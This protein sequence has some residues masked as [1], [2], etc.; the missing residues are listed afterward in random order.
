MRYFDGSTKV[1]YGACPQG[2]YN[3][4]LNYDLQSQRYDIWLGT[5]QID[6]VAR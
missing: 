2:F 4:T 1:T 3:I 6:R 5:Q